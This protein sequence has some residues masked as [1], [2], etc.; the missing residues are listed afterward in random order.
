MNFLN[1]LLPPSTKKEGGQ[2]ELPTIPEEDEADAEREGERKEEAA[3]AKKKRNFFT[4]S[5]LAVYSFTLSQTD[6]LQSNSNN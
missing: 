6:S 1:N 4:F 5:F 3:V 2:E